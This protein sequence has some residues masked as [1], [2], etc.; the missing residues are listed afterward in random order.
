MRICG[1][2]NEF[3]GPQNE[4]SGPQ[5][6]FSGPRGPLDPQCFHHV[7]YSLA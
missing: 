7:F 2:Q 3:S 1:P 6:E 4:F 5:N